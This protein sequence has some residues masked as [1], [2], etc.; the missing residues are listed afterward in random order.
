MLCGLRSHAVIA[1]WDIEVQG[2]VPTNDGILTRLHCFDWVLFRIQK[3]NIAENIRSEKKIKQRRV[4]SVSSLA[5]R[6]LK[7]MNPQFYE[8]TPLKDLIAANLINCR[9]V[10]E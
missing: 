4:P 6:K 1:M 2:F 5:L 7:Q 9:S 10:A 8:S 3:K